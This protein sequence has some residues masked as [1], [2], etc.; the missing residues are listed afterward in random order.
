MSERRHPNVVNVEEV[1]VAEMQKGKHHTRNRR[2]AAV[3]GNA[4]IGATVTEIPPGAV[5]FPFHYHCANE[6]AIYVLSGTG[7]V[8]LGDQRIAVRAGDWI[9]MPGG[10]DHAHQMIN[11]GTVPLVYLCVSTRHMVDVVTYPDSKKT[12]YVAAA[13]MDKLWHRRI[14]R[15]GESVDYWDGEPGAQ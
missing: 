12:A 6:E 13:S 9:A 8:R 11:D 15:D 10:P 5:G 7:T 14:V 1:E 4:Q 3:A 2:L